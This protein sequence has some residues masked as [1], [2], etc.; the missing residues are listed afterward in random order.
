MVTQVSWIPASGGPTIFNK[1]LLVSER[2]KNVE[3]CSCG[4]LLMAKACVLYPGATGQDSVP[5]LLLT[6]NE[7]GKC[8]LAVCAKVKEV[9]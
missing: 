5:W 6:D 4:R 3:H 2:R 9:L 1:W 8:Y 7:A